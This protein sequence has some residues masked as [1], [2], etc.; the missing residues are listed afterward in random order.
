MLVFES[1]DVNNVWDG[2]FQGADLQSG[3]YVYTAYIRNN[4]GTEKQTS[5]NILLLK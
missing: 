2:K 4:D 5:G 1:N 3:V